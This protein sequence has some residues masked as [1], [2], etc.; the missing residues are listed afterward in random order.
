VKKRFEA[1][2]PRDAAPLAQPTSRGESLA[3]KNQLI[4]SAAVLVKALHAGGYQVAAMEAS[5][6]G[7][8]AGRELIGYIDCLARRPDGSEAVID[9]KFAGR[10]YRAL[11]EEGRAVQLATYAAAR[12]QEAGIESVAVA[13]LILCDSRLH[14]PEGSPLAGS[15]RGDIV[16]GAPGIESVWNDFVAAIEAADSW[17]DGSEPV[18]ARPLQDPE[19]WPEGTG[20]VMKEKEADRACTYCPYDV[21]CGRSGLE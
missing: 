1:R 10:K 2:L 11:L 7:E 21:L 13:Y 3:M 18:T 17:L 14:T 5:V 16:D 6:H 8:I 20:L 9:F 12:A 4:D 15:R 19:E